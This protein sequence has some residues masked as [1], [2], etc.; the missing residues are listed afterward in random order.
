MGVAV[1]NVLDIDTAGR[2]TLL[3][4]QREQL[5]GFDALLTDALVL[6]VLHVQALKLVLIGKEGVVQAW[7][8]RR[9]EEG[10]ILAL[11]QAGVHQL[12]D[13]YAVVHVTNA[14]AFDA[15]IV[16]QHQQALNFQMPHRVEEGSR[17]ATHAALGAGLHGGLE[18]LVERNTAG[19]ERFTAADRAAEGANTAR[20][21]ADTGALGDI[22]HNRAGG[23]VDGVQAIAAL[24]QH[25]GAEL[26]GR[27]TH[28]GH[29]RRRQRDLK[30]RDCVIETL[31]V[32]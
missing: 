25:A 29:D 8:V 2:G 21:D 12:V 19:V 4:H 28:A 17:T 11:Q 26:A 9:A 22:F 6:L 10:D 5:N 13:L 18:V 15:T 16:F 1:V 32:V 3:H 20:V 7:H 27:G 31:H 30:G 24:D 14:V 23:G